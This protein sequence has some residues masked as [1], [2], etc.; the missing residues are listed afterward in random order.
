MLHLPVANLHTNKQ[1][2]YQICCGAVQVLDVGS[3]GNLAYCR[4]SFRRRLQGN[5]SLQVPSGVHQQSINNAY[6][7][8]DRNADVWN[9]LS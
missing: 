6:L 1:V 7:D 4:A 8:I 5:D 9:T 2:V 3:V